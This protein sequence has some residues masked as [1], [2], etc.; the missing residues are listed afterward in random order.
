M[1]ITELIMWPI[2]INGTLYTQSIMVEMECNT[3][4]D[5]EKLIN[6]CNEKRPESRFMLED[7]NSILVL[8]K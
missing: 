5:K 4:Q 7:E 1:N 8:I 3:K 2:T 6:Y